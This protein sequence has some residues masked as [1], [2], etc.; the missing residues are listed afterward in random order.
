M[1]VIRN[2]IIISLFSFTTNLVLGQLTAS[3]QL[4]NEYNECAAELNFDYEEYESYMNRTKE[5][6]DNI[7]IEDFRFTRIPIRLHVIIEDVNIIETYG[8]ED[9]PTEAS[10]CNIEEIENVIVSAIIQLNE[11]FNGTGMDFKMCDEINY[12]ANNTYNQLDFSFFTEDDAIY[13][14]S[15]LSLGEDAIDIFIAPN[16]HTG[17]GTLPYLDDS[18]VIIKNDAF[19]NSSTLAHEIGHYFNLFHT[20]RGENSGIFIFGLPDPANELLDESNCGKPNVG[21]EI[22]D[23]PPDPLYRDL[24]DSNGNPL[25]S[26]AQPNNHWSNSQGEL[27]PPGA[28]E[29]D[30]LE[31]CTFHMFISGDYQP[32]V[33][34]DEN[35]MA[36]D[37]VNTVRNFMSYAPAGC[38]DYFSPEQFERMIKSLIVDRP[39]LLVNNCDY[40]C[41]S[42]LVF[43]QQII[44]DDPLEL[45]IVEDSITSYATV[46]A[47]L[48]PGA[49]ALYDAGKRVLLKPPFEAEYGRTFCVRIEGC[50]PE[51]LKL[52]ESGKNLSASNFTIRP[53]PFSRQCTISYKLQDD[54]AI[55]ISISDIMGKKVSTLVNNE[56]QIEGEHQVNFDGSDL[57][58]GIYYCTV[59]TGDKIETQ[60]MVIAR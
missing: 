19:T 54:K 24:F 34:Y 16:T 36:F 48:L 40:T 15:D 30:D 51:V 53:N 39:E 22:C 37:V 49:F 23:T 27:D 13:L 12:I 25:V 28:L 57:P 35:Q 2:L 6:R 17:W 58:A 60:K 59:Q 38:R 14:L 4:Q 45:W 7:R 31:P 46:K 10:P 11:I 47:N 33:P 18:F 5:L 32:F 8:F 56:Q 29:Y 55:T 1:I 44:Q 9:C 21:D 52:N 50:E 20:H 26:N 3:P 42:K 43:G 41:P